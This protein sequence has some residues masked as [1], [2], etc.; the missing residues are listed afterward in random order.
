MY[1]PSISDGVLM[2]TKKISPKNIDEYIASFSEPAREKLEEIRKF[3]I[4]EA[5]EAAE[6]LAY[7]IPTFTLNG[8]LVHFAGYEGHTGFYPTPSAMKEFK[9]EMK[10]YKTSKGAVQFPL[11]EPLPEDLIRRIVRFRVEENSKS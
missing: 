8:N 2:N 6:K 3:I 1:H 5:P 11:N 7:G 9:D 4:S 10:S